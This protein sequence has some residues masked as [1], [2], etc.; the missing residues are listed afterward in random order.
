MQIHVARQQQQLGLFAP[1]EI[2]AGLSSGR[3]HVSDLA[4]REGMAAW[5][6]LGD[7]PEFRGVSVLISPTPEPAD[8]A[9]V[10][11][12]P[13]EQGK[14]LGSFF[15]TFK[16]AIINP[17]ILKTGRYA[18]G[19]WIAFCYLAVV[20]FIPFKITQLS[21][22][23]NRNEE[24][25]EILREI[26]S[27]QLG[28]LVDQLASTP[29]SPIM[30]SAIVWLLIGL[31][32]PACLAFLG[33]VHW[34]GQRILGLPVSAERT[35]AAVLMAFAVITLFVAPFHLAAIDL[36]TEMVLSAVLLLPL[37]FMYYRSLGAGTG[38][39]GW[40]HV[41][42]DCVVFL[43]ACCCCCFLPGLFFGLAT[44]GLVN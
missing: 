23:G 35:V 12:I 24:L 33:L 14:T 34:I 6:P 2:L 1:D 19:D 5:T 26:G 9:A 38:V 13:W 7:W 15:D 8:A 31:L 36:R 16:V 11:Q 41:C 28:P 29:P 17:S 43:A 44:K 30:L 37:I 42:I 18:F 27:P 10:S 21:F 32:L 40:A 4:W 22:S 25:A 3:F 20:V 39:S